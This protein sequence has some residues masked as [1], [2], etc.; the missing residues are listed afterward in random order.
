MAVDLFHNRAQVES[1]WLASALIT[2]LWLGVR[3]E[4]EEQA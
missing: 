1:L 3:R 2:V 4:D